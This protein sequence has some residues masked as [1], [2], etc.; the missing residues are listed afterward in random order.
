MGSLTFY[1][2]ACPEFLSGSS[3]RFGRDP[4]EINVEK[5]L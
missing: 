1:E 5:R 4:R 2:I 3:R